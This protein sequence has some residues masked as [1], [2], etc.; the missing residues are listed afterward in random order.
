MEG[1]TSPSGP[2]L[3]AEGFATAA[4]LHGMTDMSEIATFTAGNLLPVG[5]T[6]SAQHAIP[7]WQA[8]LQALGQSLF[9]ELV[10]DGTA[11]ANAD[12]INYR[13]PLVQS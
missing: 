4:T 11:P 12:P 8:A 6:H 1:G 7:P 13:V 2:L 10:Y 9:E 5:T 3:I